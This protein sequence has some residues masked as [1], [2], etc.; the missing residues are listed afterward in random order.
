MASCSKP[1]T[2]VRKVAFEAAAQLLQGHGTDR[3]NQKPL[4]RMPRPSLGAASGKEALG[5]L[6]DEKID[7]LITDYAMPHMTGG[8]LA[9][10]VSE[11]WSQVKIIMAAGYAELSE[12]IRAV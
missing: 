8:D 6:N 7:I 9:A 3:R 11:E 12:S 2:C 10:A 4:V 1:S 5:I